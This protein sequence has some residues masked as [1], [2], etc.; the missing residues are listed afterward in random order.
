MDTNTSHE[1]TIPARHAPII[2][3]LAPFSEIRQVILFGS[4]ASGAA[5]PDSDLDIGI[6]AECPLT[7]EKR[8]RLIEALAMATGR[9]VDLV[10]LRTAGQPLLGEILKTGVRLVSRNEDYARLIFRNILEREDF[11]PYRE[12]ILKERREAWLDQ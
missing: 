6:E 2:K 11:L 7:P 10:D 12:R 5:G 3:A 9:P 8:I 1:S 4:V